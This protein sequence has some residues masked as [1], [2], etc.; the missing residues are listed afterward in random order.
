MLS[1]LIE[2]LLLTNLKAIVSQNNRYE[3]GNF[4]IIKNKRAYTL[5][6]QIAINKEV[7]LN[8][9]KY[10]VNVLLYT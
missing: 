5:N 4:Y 8:Y 9:L 2:A 6:I 1:T 3:Q 10:L 7:S